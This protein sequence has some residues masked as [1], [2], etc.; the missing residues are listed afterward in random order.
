MAE[1][2]PEVL[3]AAARQR[4]VE[5]TTVGRR[6]GQ[7]RRAVVWLS[8]DGRRLFIRSGG[9]LGRHWPRNL[10]AKAEG[11]LHVGGLE[12]PFKARHL[13]DVVHAREVSHLV[14]AKYGPQVAH[15]TEGQPPTPGEQAS[16]E[17]TPG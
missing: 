8:T 7:P 9:G 15:S 5:I 6:S 14:R 13:T 10:L 1:F 17:L 3:T 12:V 4:E 11:V 2:A 16:F